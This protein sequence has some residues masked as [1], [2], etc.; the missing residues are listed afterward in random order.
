MHTNRFSA[1]ASCSVYLGA[2]VRH[3]P[4]SRSERA[5]DAAEGVGAVNSPDTAA[6]QT[7]VAGVEM[8]GQRERQPHQERGND[9]NQG[10]QTQVERHDPGEALLDQ[11]EQQVEEIGQGSQSRH[12]EPAQG[13][14]SQLQPGQVP[15]IRFPLAQHPGIEQAPQPQAGQER[16]QDGGEGVDTGT[17]R[18]SQGSGPAN[19]VG[20]GCHSRQAETERHQKRGVALLACLA[21]GVLRW[22]HLRL[23]ATFRSG[24]R[25]RAQIDGPGPDGQIHGR[26]Q[27]Q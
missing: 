14:H 4:E 20:H 1:E 24:V 11:G 25:S 2:P 22:R 27:Q 21:G 13:S 17:Q 9:Q 23:L 26:G 19:L 3:Q 16:D 5:Q 15:Q 12:R 8:G 18:E 10:G 7:Q 6:E